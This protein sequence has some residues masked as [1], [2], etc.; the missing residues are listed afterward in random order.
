LVKYKF[1]HV[2]CHCRVI[3]SIK[4][5]RQV[6]LTSILVIQYMYLSHTPAPLDITSWHLGKTKSY[7]GMALR[8]KLAWQWKCWGGVWN[9]WVELLQL[10]KC[11]D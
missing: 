5:H 6:P 4:V 11:P 3:S 7:L 9:S 8:E 10:L 2:H 1:K